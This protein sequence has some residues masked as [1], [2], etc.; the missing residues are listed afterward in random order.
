VKIRSRLG[1]YVYKTQKV[2]TAGKNQEIEESHRTVSPSESPEGI[3]PAGPFI[4][5][6]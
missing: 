5:D 3:D 4:S 1:C 2:I 6:F